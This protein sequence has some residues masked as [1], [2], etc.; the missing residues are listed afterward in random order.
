MTYGNCWQS[1]R[2]KHEHSKSRLSVMERKDGDD[3]L[4]PAIMGR[5]VLPQGG[6]AQW[7]AAAAM[8]MTKANY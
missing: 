3:A 5:P 4:S 8:K 6:R 2:A 7:T 1:A